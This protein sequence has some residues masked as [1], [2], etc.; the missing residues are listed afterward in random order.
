M[1]VKLPQK[2]R[3]MKA[4]LSAAAAR[5]AVLLA[6][7]QLVVDHHRAVAMDELDRSPPRRSH[8]RNARRLLRNAGAV[9]SIPALVSGR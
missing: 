4:R 9:G 5:I 2:L 1:T 8:Y 3:L 6:G 7:D